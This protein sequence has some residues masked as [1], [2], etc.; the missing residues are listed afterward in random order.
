MKRVPALRDLSSEHHSGLVSVRRIRKAVTLPEFQPVAVWE[1]IADRFEDELEPHS[2]KEEQGLLPA[3][4]T[5]G[6]QV[7]VERTLQELIEMRD[8][9]RVAAPVDL[10]SFTQL[11]SNHIRF[12]EKELFEVAQSCLSADELVALIL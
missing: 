9:V 4:R 11:L 1:D 3:L 12:E 2:Q 7:L 6:E 10:L 8:I 5:S